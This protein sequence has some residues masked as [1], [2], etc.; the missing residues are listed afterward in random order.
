MNEFV[1]LEISGRFGRFVFTRDGLPAEAY[2]EMS[3][4]KSF[5][6]LV[7]LEQMNT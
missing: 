3:G 1:D 6:L 2:V 4:S 5:D 7:G